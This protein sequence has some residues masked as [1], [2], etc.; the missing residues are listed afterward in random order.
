VALAC[1]LRRLPLAGEQVLV[2]LAKSA[3]RVRTRTDTCL[4]RR[5]TAYMRT[6]D[7]SLA[8]VRPMGRSQTGERVQ[9]HESMFLLSASSLQDV[10]T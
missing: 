2:L 9:L 4:H 10:L 7:A 1:R 6:C 8:S 3:L 5:V